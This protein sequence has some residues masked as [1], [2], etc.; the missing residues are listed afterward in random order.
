MLVALTETELIIFLKQLFPF[1]SFCVHYLHFYKGLTS[2]PASNSQK[3]Q[4]KTCLFPVDEW[5][6]AMTC[7]DN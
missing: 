6:Q 1:A 3:L 4:K 7:L 2:S 5:Y